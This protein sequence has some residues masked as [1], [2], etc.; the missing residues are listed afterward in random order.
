[1]QLKVRI[2]K[3]GVDDLQKE[4]DVLQKEKWW[5]EFEQ[6]LPDWAFL[7]DE[8]RKKQAKL[9]RIANRIRTLRRKIYE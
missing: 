3:E 7:K 5:M 6:E 8:K 1:M 2:A 4:L 9:V